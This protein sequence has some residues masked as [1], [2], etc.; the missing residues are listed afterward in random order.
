MLGIEAVNI[1]QFVLL[2]APTRR[3]S[4]RKAEILCE[5]MEESTAEA[6]LDEARRQLAMI[7]AV[8]KE[9]VTAD[10]QEQG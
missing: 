10:E 8:A 7:T 3:I 6:F 1:C 4:R 9:V 2:L 5:Q